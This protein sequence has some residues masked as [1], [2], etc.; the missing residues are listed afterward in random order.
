M[1]SPVSGIS[2]GLGVPGVRGDAGRE[3]SDGV[4]GFSTNA[5][6]AGVI[7]VNTAGVGVVGRSTDH[8]G[9][10]G[11]TSNKDRAGVV[12][13]NDG[14]GPGVSGRSK[15]GVGVVGVGPVAAQ[16]VGKVEVT[17]DVEISKGFD[18]ILDGGDYAEALT[19]TDASV[20]AGLV[21]VLGADGEVHPCAQDYDSAVAG[22][23][24][25][26]GGVIA[27]SLRSSWIVTITALM[28]H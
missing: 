13:T 26:A 17:G 12:G 24:S 16:F 18:L 9:V 6:R 8:D 1:T 7:G 22:I 23:V 11:I 21:V 4:E 25:G 19:T 5:S 2:N 3:N 20:E 10:E 28:S 14:N 15:F 27:S